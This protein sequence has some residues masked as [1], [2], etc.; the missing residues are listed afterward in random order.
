MFAE[1]LAE[2]GGGGAEAG[3]SPE[4]EGDALGIHGERVAF[5]MRGGA[6]SLEDVDGGERALL[7]QG[8]VSGEQPEVARRGQ[9]H[10]REGMWQSGGLRERMKD[11]G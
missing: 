5:R 2:G 8:E 6:V 3:G 1:H 11:E 9:E 10:H 7:G 4:S